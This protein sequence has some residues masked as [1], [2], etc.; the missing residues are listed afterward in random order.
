MYRINKLLEINRQLFHTNDLAVLWG[1]NNRQ[2][3]Y[4][5]ISRYIKQGILIKI[6]KGL[7]STV[8]L[9]DLDP[10]DLGPA[11]AH[12]YTYLSTETVLAYA[13]VI[14]QNVYDYTYIAD[15]SRKI[16]LGKWN[17]RF[18]QMK[19]DFLFHPLGIEKKNNRFIATINRAAADIL[20]YAP[21]YYFDSPELLNFD[22]IR[23]IQKEVGFA[24]N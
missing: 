3:L 4:Q 2:S 5:T 9:E 11:V 14:S 17:F 15:F 16:A 23:D 19:D 21:D 18:R 20:Y 7:Y 8:P 6:Y 10:L 13:G 12:Q 24:G 1:M 22:N